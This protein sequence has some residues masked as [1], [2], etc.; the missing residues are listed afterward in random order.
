MNNFFA[1]VLL[2][3]DVSEVWNSNWLRTTF[4]A[5][6]TIDYYILFYYVVGMAQ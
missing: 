2:T 4:K 3:V 6:A 1:N 5:T